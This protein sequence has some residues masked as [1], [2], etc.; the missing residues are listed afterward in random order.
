MAVLADNRRPLT[1]PAPA[2]PGAIAPDAVEAELESLLTDLKQCQ[3]R[4]LAAVRDHRA[5][6]AKADQDAIR[7]A[8]E[9]HRAVTDEL[10]TLEDR[11][12]RLGARV[13]GRTAAGARP[14]LGELLGRVPATARERLT[15]LAASVREI[16]ITAQ[17][18]QRA[19]GDAALALAG[20]MEGVMRGVAAKVSEAG[21]YGRRGYVETPAR[22]VGMLDVSR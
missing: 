12:V 18:E 3:D 15:V 1:R 9:R 13:M 5:A 4:L 21:V 14:T 10:R 11:R 8:L 16:A 19:L 22:P 20:H 7:I 2:A 6:I 17:R